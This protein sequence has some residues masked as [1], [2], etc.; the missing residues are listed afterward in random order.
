MS[1]ILYLSSGPLHYSYTE[2]YG[3]KLI[4]RMDQGIIDF[5]RSLVPKWVRLNSQMYPAH[6]SVVRK[7]VPVNLGFW[8][9]YEGEVV[10]FEYSPVVCN[11]GVYYWLNVFSRRLEEVRVELGLSPTRVFEGGLSCFHATVGNIK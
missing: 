10:D 1:E 2:G 6:V 9:R 8:G 4:V 5:Y 11:E 3:Y 7:V